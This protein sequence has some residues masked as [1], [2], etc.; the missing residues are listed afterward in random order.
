MLLTPKVRGRG[1]RWRIFTGNRALLCADE[2][3]NEDDGPA[4]ILR[5]HKLAVAFWCIAPMFADA[6][7]QLNALRAD[8]T[9]ETTLSAVRRARSDQ[10]PLISSS[11]NRRLRSGCRT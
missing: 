10:Q 8:M 4:F 1:C 11:S 6:V 5:E 2:P 3:E 7:K 9:K